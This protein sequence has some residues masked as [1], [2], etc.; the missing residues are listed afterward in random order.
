[1]N[2][3]VE[4]MRGIGLMQNGVWSNNYAYKMEQVYNRAKRG[5]TTTQFFQNKGE[6]DADPFGTKFSEKSDSK[7]QYKAIDEIGLNQNQHLELMNVLGI[8]PD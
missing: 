7:E 4:R 3:G 8:V 5:A 1:M 6:G 2:E